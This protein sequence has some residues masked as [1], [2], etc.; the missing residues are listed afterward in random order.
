M[1]SEAFLPT[2]WVIYLLTDS[3]SHSIHTP[4]SCP[5]AVAAA[6]SLLPNQALSRFYHY[7]LNKSVSQ[8]FPS[9]PLAPSTAQIHLTV[10][11][12][13]EWAPPLLRDNLRLHMLGAS[14]YLSA[15]KRDGASQEPHCEPKLCHEQPKA[16]AKTQAPQ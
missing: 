12:G 3:K 7:P 6:S 4:P 13:A 2:L 14:W 16:H 1:L 10:W 5:Y 9:L 11:M 15:A 8:R